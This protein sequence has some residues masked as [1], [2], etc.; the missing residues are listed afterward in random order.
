MA[1]SDTRLITFAISHY[2]E[3]A[4]WALDWHGVDYREIGWPP[5][6]HRILAKRAGARHGSVPILLTGD[7]VVEGSDTIIDWAEA[8]AGGTKPG[9]CPKD[10]SD[11]IR[12][13]EARLDKRAGVNVRRFIYSHVMPDQAHYVKPMLFANTGFFHR[14]AGNLMWPT[15]IKMIVK[16]YKINATS[17][18]EARAVLEQELT[19][20]EDRLAG[21]N[22]LIGNTF[23]RADL[24]AASLLAPFARPTEMPLYH[25][26]ILPDELMATFDELSDRP[27][28]QWVR[29][30][31]RDYR[32]T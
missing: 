7:D 20:L 10:L 6:I 27:V 2:C 17:A 16:G 9:L 24:T 25:D 32:N 21:H 11:E 5:G 28:M 8:N 22:H 14:M 23:T 18:A 15:C 30:I 29:Q 4:R 1:Q 13:T 12:Q 3:K 26:A 31:Y 19:W